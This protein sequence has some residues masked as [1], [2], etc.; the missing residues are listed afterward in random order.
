MSS[1]YQSLLGA[2]R[3]EWLLAT[4]APPRKFQDASSTV[5]EGRGGTRGSASAR[6]VTAALSARK[7]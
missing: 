1:Q 2:H 4:P 5:A 6:R 7:Q 3:S